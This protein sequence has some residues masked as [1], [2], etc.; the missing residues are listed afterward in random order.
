MCVALVVSLGERVADW[1]AESVSEAMGLP[2]LGSTYDIAFGGMGTL[3]RYRN[4]LE[5]YMGTLPVH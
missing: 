5:I 4:G 2:G 1:T 3:G